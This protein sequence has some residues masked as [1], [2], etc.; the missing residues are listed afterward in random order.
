MLMAQSPSAPAADP[1]A[2]L[3][4]LLGTWSATTSAAGNSGGEAMGTYT[5][6]R[7]LDGHVLERTSTAAA[8]K[9]PADFNCKHRDQISIFPDAN[10]Q[11]IHHSSLLALFLDNEGH[12]IYYTVT[13][14]DAHTAIF[15]SQ[16]P[17]SAPKFR[18]SYHLEGNVMSGKFEMAAPGSD[19]FHSYLEWSG[20]KIK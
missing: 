4:F 9:G 16:S 13:T 10:A 20:V 2:S 14:P 5:F 1:L 12:V 19:D 18:L 3:D 11:A 15:N 8:C 6:S 17:A 7:G